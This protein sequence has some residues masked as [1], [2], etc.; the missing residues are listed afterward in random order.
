M[1]FFIP[2]WSFWAVGRKKQRMMLNQ[3]TLVPHYPT[4]LKA[5]VGEM[6]FSDKQNYIKISSFFLFWL[7]KMEWRQRWNRWENPVWVEHP[8]FANLKKSTEYSVYLQ[9]RREIFHLLS[10]DTEIPLILI[11]PCKRGI[12]RAELDIGDAHDSSSFNL[13]F[14]T[15]RDLE[16]YSLSTS[17]FEK[18]GTTTSCIPQSNTA[19]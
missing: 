13:D 18:M 8:S 5:S 10:K 1:H 12:R 6:I 9:T 16:D 17:S 7:Y 11:I 14:R 2:R 4:Y 15:M 3:H 19:G